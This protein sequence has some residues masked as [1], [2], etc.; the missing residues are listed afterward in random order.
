MSVHLRGGKGGNMH[1]RIASL[2][3]IE[4][5]DSILTKGIHLELYYIDKFIQVSSRFWNFM[6]F[7]CPLQ[8]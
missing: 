6:P 4:A 1:L 2:G 3:V 8:I 7:L 5:L